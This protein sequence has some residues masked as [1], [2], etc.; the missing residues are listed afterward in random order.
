M[1]LK[2]LPEQHSSLTGKVCLQ[3]SAALKT[4]TVLPGVCVGGPGGENNSE[5]NEHAAQAMLISALC[6]HEVFV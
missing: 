5:S 6:Y 2:E 4:V 1:C 3:L